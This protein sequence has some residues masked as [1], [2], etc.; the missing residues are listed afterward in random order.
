MNKKKA[1]KLILQIGLF[2]IAFAVTISVIQ[3]SNSKAKPI[4]AQPGGSDDQPGLSVGEL[5]ALPQLPSLTGNPVALGNSSKKYILCGFFST[6]CPGCSLDSEFW[7][8]LSQEAAK[9]N[10]A[11]YLISLDQDPARVTRFAKAYGF[12]NLPVLVDQNNDASARFKIS[13][14][15]QYVLLASNG[16]VLGRWS[17]LSHTDAENHRAESPAEFLEKITGP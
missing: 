5:V 14:V 1:A 11:F 7:Q 6:S 15:P 17:G 12:E 13:L 3:K 8:S 4:S 10:V 2:A 16:T 9:R